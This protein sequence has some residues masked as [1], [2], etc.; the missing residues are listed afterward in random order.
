MHCCAA[1]VPSQ[2]YE[3]ACRSRAAAAASS[4]YQPL[5]EAEKAALLEKGRQERLAAEAELA[6]TMAST[7]S[8]LKGKEETD[9]GHW[10]KVRRAGCCLRATCTHV[11][12]PH[13]TCITD[14]SLMMMC[15]FWHNYCCPC[16]SRCRHG[17]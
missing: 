15:C 3:D 13:G 14:A 16:Q 8:S 11:Q 17:R 12:Q 4:N 2:E 9:R 5:S 10:F 1:G 6:S 7:E